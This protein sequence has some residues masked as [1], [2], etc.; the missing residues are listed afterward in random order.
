MALRYTAACVI[1]MGFAER[2]T[3]YY[4][5]DFS[6]SQDSRCT[7]HLHLSTSVLTTYVRRKI[8]SG[9]KEIV[10]HRSAYLGVDLPIKL[11]VTYTEAILRIRA[12][13]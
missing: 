3:I 4:H 2:S 6:V 8:E 10:K 5:Y 13:K 12:E 1:G 11:L 7:Y 9:W